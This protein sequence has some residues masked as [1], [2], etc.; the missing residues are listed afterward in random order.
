MENF[1]SEIN[2]V[3]QNYPKIF[4]LIQI[5]KIVE[6]HFKNDYISL[7]IETDETL[8]KGLIIIKEKF[9]QSQK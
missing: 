9:F 5:G 7:N 6:I 4:R 2:R 8:Y 3:L 1:S